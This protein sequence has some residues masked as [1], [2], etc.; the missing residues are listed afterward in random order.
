MNNRAFSTNFEDHNGLLHKF[1]KSGFG[2]LRGMDIDIDYEDVFQENCV[3]FVRAKQTYNPEAG[4]SFSAYM[5]RAVW[6]NFNKLAE[7]LER[8][9]DELGMVSVEEL[10]ETDEECDSALDNIS[11]SLCEAVPST[12]DALISFQEARANIAKL[13]Q[14]ARLVVRD[15]MKP[16]QALIDQHAAEYAH[17]Q[18]AKSMDEYAPR[19]PLEIDLRYV[20]KYHGMKFYKFEQELK[21]KLGIDSL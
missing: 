1:T 17:Y 12:E 15:I 20:V 9:R 8:E 10:T 5:G 11:G 16:S 19:V 18:H 4:I 3:S 13:S 21:E 7:K 2:R 14:K 6:N